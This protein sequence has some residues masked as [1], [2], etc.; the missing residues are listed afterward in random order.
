MTVLTVTGSLLYLAGVVG[1]TV[2]ANVPLND[3][4]AA[5]QPG[6]AAADRFWVEYSRR[7]TRWNLLRS[8]AALAA[9]AAY[10]AALAS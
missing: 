1:V 6:T 4:L 7:W 5:Q 9:A 8:L 3:R 2:A 10:V